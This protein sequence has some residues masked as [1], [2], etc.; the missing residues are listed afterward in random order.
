MSE[1][2]IDL[3][4]A[5]TVAPDVDAIKAEVEATDCGDPEAD[6]ERA[7]VLRYHRRVTAK[8][9]EIERVKEAHRKLVNRLESDLKG[10][11][12]VYT[13]SV[14]AIVRKWLTGKMRSI[15]TPWGRIGFR[16]VP[17]RV[18]VPDPAAFVM[19]CPAA[20][21]SLS[22]NLKAISAAIKETGEVPKGV[23]VGEAEERFY[24]S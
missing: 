13:A 3:Y 2:E 1:N 8:K 19:G 17:P 18:S 6:E 16:N 7:L 10:L 4:E 24:A 22:P 5:E 23:E 12:Y 9:D 14:S 20:F 21:V 11:D 15:A